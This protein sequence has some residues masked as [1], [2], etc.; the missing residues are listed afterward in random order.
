MSKIKVIHVISALNV[1]GAEALLFDLL[2]NIDRERFDVKVLCFFKEGGLVYKFID[3]DIEIKF[4]EEKRKSYFK[5]FN[6]IVEYFKEENPDIVHTHLYGADFFGT[7][8]AKKA[9]IKNIVSTEHNLNKGEGFIKNCCKFFSIRFDKKIIA[10]SKAVKEYV[11]KRYLVRNKKIEIINNFIDINKWRCDYK[12]LLNDKIKI[13]VVARLVE[14][15]GHS[16][17][18]NALS[19]V[20][21]DFELFVI[22][23]GPKRKELENLVWKL[24]ITDKVK[25]LGSCNNVPEL[26]QDVDIVIQ[27]SLWEGFGI[28]VAEALAASK[29]L[30]VSNVD[31]MLDI[32]KDKEN[33]LL[34]NV[35]DS[36]DL[37]DKL[38]WINKNRMEAISISKNA[39]NSVQ[40]FD[41][42]SIVFNYE[43]VYEYLINN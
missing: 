24:K 27:P 14:Q 28:T 1:G 32:V 5:I 11:N 13:A 35:G 3:S 10:I 20:D 9:G 8:A 6:K 23:D 17:L 34:F 18:F 33:G 42:K 2:E 25:F 19:K 21:F 22:G 43:T 26:L 40:K 12:I 15:K 31:G 39:L 37:A 7:F 41:V 30:V 16:V 4:I 29:L 38:K 36:N